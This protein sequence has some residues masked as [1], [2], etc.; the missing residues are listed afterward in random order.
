M[1]GD[2]GILPLR[3]EAVGFD[4]GGQ[5][6]LDGID[7]E[8]ERGRPVVVLGPNGAG[9]SLLLRLAHGLLAPTRGRVRWLGA[10]KGA[11]GTRQAMLFAEAVLLRRSVAANVVH[12]LSVRGVVGAERAARVARVLAE[13][14]LDERAEQPARSLSSGEKQRL[15]LA[16][17]WAVEPEV[18]FLDEPTGSLDPAATGQVE[19]IV[20]RLAAE[21]RQIVMTTHDLGQARRIAGRVL[22]LHR[23]RLVEDA[24]VGAFFESPASDEAR[25]FLAGDLV[26]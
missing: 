24:P 15:A 2:G 26:W 14:G 16:R 21:G 18:L 22:F 11:A 23:G 7:F 1:S 9:K 6:L 19:T 13:T 20:A 8:V 5:R 17:A 3:F 10:G 4:A 25:A 12:A